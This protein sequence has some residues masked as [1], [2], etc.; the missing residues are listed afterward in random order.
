M[1]LSPQ[2]ASQPH[3]TPDNHQQLIWYRELTEPSALQWG[4][5]ADSTLPE[6]RVWS[7][8]SYASAPPC[9]QSSSLPPAK[10]LHLRRNRTPPFPCHLL[11]SSGHWAADADRIWL[12]CHL[13]RE[14]SIPAFAQRRGHVLQPACAE[15]PW[16]GSLCLQYPEETRGGPK[17]HHTC[18]SAAAWPPLLFTKLKKRWEGETACNN[19]NK[20]WTCGKQW[21]LERERLL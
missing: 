8:P 11:C 17:N 2:W 20:K 9:S 7:H 18:R 1:T 16:E 13:P 4:Y 5:W 10:E 6:E 19:Q 15:V 21:G 12:C 14:T 3:G